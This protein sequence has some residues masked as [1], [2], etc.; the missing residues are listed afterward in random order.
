VEGAFL[1]GRGVYDFKGGR[2]RKF[3]KIIPDGG[4]GRIIVKIIPDRGRG[5]R[6]FR[7]SASLKK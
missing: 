6:N 5:R 2:G 4:R 3:V 1:L 7:L